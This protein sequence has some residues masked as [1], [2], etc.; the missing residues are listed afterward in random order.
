MKLVILTGQRESE[1]CNALWSEFDLGNGMWRLPANRRTKTR[2]AH[3]VHLAREALAILESVKA[4]TGKERHTFASPLKEKQPIYGR[5]VCNALAT[6]FRTGKLPNV[7]PCHVHDFRRTLISRLPDLGFEPF[8]GHKIANH[9]LSGV[10]AHYNHNSYEQQRKAALE[11]WA[12]RIEALAGGTKVTQ[13][14]RA[15]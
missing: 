5:S 7:T 3:L 13:L 15:A 4:I 2:R 12:A 6:L 14:H 9:V 1:V 10:F 11:A 8:I